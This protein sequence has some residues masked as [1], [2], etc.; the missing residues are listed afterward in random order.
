MRPKLW[1]IRNLQLFRSTDGLDA[2]LR[3]IGRVE[4]WGHRAEVSMRAD[5]AEVQIVLSGVVELTDGT[6]DA[7][8]RL[9]AGD[10]FGELGSSEQIC[11]L[12]AYDDL[13]IASIDRTVFDAETSGRLGE[14]RASLGVVRRRSLAMPVTSLL[15]SPPRLRLANTLLHVVDTVGHRNGE[16]GHLDFRPSAR[17]LARVS[18]LA[19]STVR[20]LLDSFAQD[21]LITLGRSELVV[22]SLETMRLLGTT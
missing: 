19:D 10:L 12:H 4:R 2:R 16:R 15:Y 8:V 17:G 1:Y 9:S 6:F 3:D 7:R 18:G 14:L 20:E 13:V 22:P 21:D 5:P 11:R